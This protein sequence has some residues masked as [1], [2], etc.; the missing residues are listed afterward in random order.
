[1]QYKKI[2]GLWV[3]VL[4]K[5]EKLIEKLKEFLEKEN[6][7]SGYLSGIG[8]VSSVELAHY[9]LQEKRYTTKKFDEPLEIVSL[10]GNVAMKEEE[11]IIHCHIAVGTN[12]MNLY[13]GHLIEASVAATCEIV[14]NEFEVPVN[15]KK[16]P[17]TGLN[18]ITIS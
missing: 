14:F 10:L 1:M 18:L 16:D 11:K 5:G 2:D 17:N 7:K 3:I 15:K 13:G 12:K 6:I 9:N 4:K 8:A